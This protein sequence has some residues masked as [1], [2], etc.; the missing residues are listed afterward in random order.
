[1][2]KVKDSYLDARRAQIL[3]AAII[4]FARQGFHRA[5]MHNIVEQS[6][7]SPGA[8]YNY[9]GSKDDIIEAIAKERQK[10]EKRRIL[11]A[12][13][14][15]NVACVVGRIR[16]AF[17]GELRAPRERLRRR[18]SIQLWAEAQR[19]PRIKKTVGRGVTQMRKLLSGIIADA[20]RR[21]EMAPDLHPDAVARFM[22]GCPFT[23]I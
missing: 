7:L 5:T 9:F 13:K 16:D 20:Q 19:N 23:G 3:D 21:H 14:E 17:L 11:E 22:I 1:M 10:K 18:V 8:I 2:P 6:K 12:Q 15:P 4:C